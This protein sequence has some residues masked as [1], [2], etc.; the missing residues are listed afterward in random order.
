MLFRP[1]TSKS[2]L[3]SN[4][5]SCIFVFVLLSIVLSGYYYYRVCTSTVI[6]N[7]LLGLSMLLIVHMYDR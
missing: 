1:S 2:K 3:T 4:I 5:G 6:N 7:T